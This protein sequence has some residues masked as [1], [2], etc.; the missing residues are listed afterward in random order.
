MGQNF[1]DTFY[2]YLSKYDTEVFTTEKK[3]NAGKKKNIYLVND[4]VQFRC[5]DYEIRN[6][7]YYRIY[8]YISETF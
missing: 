2:A 7:G 3:Y 6:L 5:L 4:K 8:H 1:K